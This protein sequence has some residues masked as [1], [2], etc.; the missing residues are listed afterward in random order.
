[1][2]SSFSNFT[3]NDLDTDAKLALKL[4]QEEQDKVDF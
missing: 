2:V 4:Q 1:M 3:E